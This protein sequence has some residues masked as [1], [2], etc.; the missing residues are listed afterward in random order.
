MTKEQWARASAGLLAAAVLWAIW[1]NFSGALERGEGPLEAIWGL[2]RMFT[3][4]TSLLVGLVFAR[5]AW[6]GTDS[7]SP[8]V[9][10]GI[11]LGIVLVGVVFN[12]LL[13]KMPHQT[14]W[15]AISDYIHHVAAP[16]AAPLWWA[17]FARHGALRWASS[18]VWA[19]YPL[20]YSVYIVVRAQFMPIGA[21]IQSRYPYFFMDAD[22]LGWP[23][24][25]LNMIGISLGFVLF[26]M[27]AVAIDKWM[28]RSAVRQAHPNLH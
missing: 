6:C 9:I 22:L 15:H 13:S 12:L 10:G 28:A 1:P 14:I 19:L 8:L 17:I 26:G 4:I 21:G 20:A 7:V 3:I 2:L 24:A 27:V 11:M 16:I 23:Q 25:L 18:L 5:I